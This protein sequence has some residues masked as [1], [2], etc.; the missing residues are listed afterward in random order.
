M[1]KQA[2]DEDQ[3]WIYI[4]YGATFYSITELQSS[5]EEI[6]KQR[7]VTTDIIKMRSL[8]TQNSTLQRTYQYPAI[9]PKNEGETRLGRRKLRAR[10]SPI[11]PDYA[12]IFL[13]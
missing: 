2:A 12:D 4:S 5:Y 8:P 11:R 10:W 6:Q 1:G 9:R 7:L 13:L 3:H